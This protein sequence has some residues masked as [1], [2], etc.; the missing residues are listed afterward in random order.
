MS[1]VFNQL[2][3]I[4]RRIETSRGIMGPFAP[5]LTLLLWDLLSRKCA[6]MVFAK[7]DVTKFPRCYFARFGAVAAPPRQLLAF[8]V[9]IIVVRRATPFQQPRRVVVDISVLECST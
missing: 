1:P 6:F 7:P 8:Y 2:S 4:R 3:V 5:S 9:V